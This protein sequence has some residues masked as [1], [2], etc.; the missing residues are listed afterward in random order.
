MPAALQQTLVFGSSSVIKVS[1]S[2][3]TPVLQ[4]L[5]SHVMF[6]YKSLVDI[7]VYDHSS[8]KYR[9]VILYNLLST[10]FNSR[11]VVCTYTREGAPIQSICGLYS[12]AN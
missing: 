10:V 8:F 7:A 12:S 5:K 3:L 9:F 11:L 1:L 6:Q 2:R 4:L